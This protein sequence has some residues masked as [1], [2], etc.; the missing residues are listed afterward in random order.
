MCLILD[1][2]ETNN[3]LLFFQDNGQPVRLF[4]AMRGRLRQVAASLQAA[5]RFRHISRRDPRPADWFVDKS[6][7]D[8]T[9]ERKDKP[10]PTC[11]GHRIVVNPSLPSHYKVMYMCIQ[12]CVS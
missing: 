8:E 5:V 11:W 10:A 4:S 7:Q 9:T 3:F 6:N 1:T 12:L 2:T